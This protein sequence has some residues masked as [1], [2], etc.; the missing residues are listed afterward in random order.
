VHPFKLFLSAKKEEKARLDLIKGPEEKKVASKRSFLRPASPGRKKEKR[1]HPDAIVSGRKEE[2]ERG[3]RGGLCSRIVKK[4]K[5]DSLKEGKRGKRKLRILISI[6]RKKDRIY[7]DSGGEARKKR[8]GKSERA[9]IS[10]PERGKGP[11]PPKIKN[12]KEGGEE[13]GSGIV[14]HLHFIT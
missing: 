8:K 13:E 10:P 6:S 5:R 3:S 12:E 9:S 11:L 7:L 14:L 1:G 2:N 4:G